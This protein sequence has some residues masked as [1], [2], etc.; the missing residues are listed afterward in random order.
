MSCLLTHMNGD[1]GEVD[2][3]TWTEVMWGEEIGGELGMKNC[4]LH[5]K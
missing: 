3:G 5:V 4:G 2:G 1:R